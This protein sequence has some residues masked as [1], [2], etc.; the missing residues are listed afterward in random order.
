M[1]SATFLECRMISMKK[2]RNADKRKKR[3]VV[4]VLWTMRNIRMLGQ[5][6]PYRISMLATRKM[7]GTAKEKLQVHCEI[8]YVN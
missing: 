5:I 6:V 8:D 3:I 4:Q 7:I 1:N 2:L